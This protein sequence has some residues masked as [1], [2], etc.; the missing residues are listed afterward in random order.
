MHQIQ[1][2]KLQSLQHQ[3]QEKHEL[4]MERQEQLQTLKTVAKKQNNHEM[5]MVSKIGEQHS[6]HTLSM[7]TS[8][9]SSTASNKDRLMTPE[10]TLQAKKISSSSKKRHASIFEER[11]KHLVEEEGLAF[12]SSAVMQLQQDS[13]HSPP[14]RKSTSGGGAKKQL[15]FSTASKRET[16]PEPTSCDEP[17][18][19][20]Y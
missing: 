16:S 3:L 4:L 1:N 15:D 5:T 17:E 13:D 19:R 9:N 14:G 10:A 2:N 8:F 6:D 12:R 7:E 20:Y 11:T 18:E